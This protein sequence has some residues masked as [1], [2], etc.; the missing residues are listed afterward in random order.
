MGLLKIGAKK[1]FSKLK[2]NLEMNNHYLQSLQKFFASITH[3]IVFYFLSI[4]LFAFVFGC[5]DSANLSTKQSVEAVSDIKQTQVRFIGQ[6]LNEGKREKLVRDFIQKYE[7]ENQDVDVLLKFP[8]EVFVGEDGRGGNEN[9]IAE[10]VYKEDPEWDIVRLNNQYDEVLAIYNDPNWAKDNLVDF[11]QFPEFQNNTIPTLLTQKM[12]DRWGGIIP[13][14]FIEGQFWTLWSNKSVA[15]KVGIQIKQY[16]MGVD[17]FLGYLKAID[18]YNK[19]NPDNYITPI[20]FTPNWPTAYLM[21]LQLYFSAL[22]NQELQFT[23]IITEEKLIAWHKTLQ[24][25]EEVAKYNPF[26]PDWQN[27][28]WGESRFDLINENCL[29]YIN[30]SWMYNIWNQENEE[31]TRNCFPNEFPV[32]NEINFYPASY[33]IMWGVLKKAKNRDAAVDFLLAMNTPDMAEM[34]VQYT[35][36]PTGIKGKLTDVSFGSDQFESFSLHV[37]KNYGENTYHFGEYIEQY[38]V[39]ELPA[40]YSGYWEVLIGQLTA[41]EAIQRIRLARAQ[42]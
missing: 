30:G 36:C 28:S 42:L 9:F 12:K 27:V 19:K 1:E 13:G 10:I 37:Q 20:H 6:W 7:F 39:G 18:S 29:F 4:G 21:V 35:K 17:D 41:D 32:F 16:G 24:V 34:W 25:L 14:P 33:Q 11:S 22:N 31:L 8:E 15:E 23:D 38:I 2:V 3:N 26:N 5:T 40:R